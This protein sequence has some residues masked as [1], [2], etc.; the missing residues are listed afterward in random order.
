MDNS[1]QPY[2]ENYE[3]GDTVTHEGQLWII[4]RIEG[5]HVDLINPMDPREGKNG[6][7]FNKLVIE[8]VIETAKVE[9]RTNSRLIPARETEV[10]FSKEGVTFELENLRAES[11]KSAYEIIAKSGI[12]NGYGSLT[13]PDPKNQN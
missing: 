2:P 13:F 11:A 9:T 6:V 3:Q 10:Q 1:E 7:P 8:P 12:R 4:Q 5:D